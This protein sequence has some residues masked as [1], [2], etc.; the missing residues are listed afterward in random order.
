MHVGAGVLDLAQGGG[1]ERALVFLSLRDEVAAQVGV[2]LVHADADV[3][4]RAVGEVEAEV[5]T[6]AGGLVEEDVHAAH[7]RGGQRLLVAGL[8]AVEGRVAREDRALEGG[9][10]LGDVVDG[11]RPPCRTPS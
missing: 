8:V 9:D 7:L 3:L 11:E 10:G 1:L 2:G 5:A 6:V 4:V